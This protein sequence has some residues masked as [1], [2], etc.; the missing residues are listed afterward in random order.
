MPYLAELDAHES[1]AGLHLVLVCG[2][3]PEVT[4]GDGVKSQ[5][6]ER[7]ETSFSFEISAEFVDVF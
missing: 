7:S 1:R 6:T 5:E 4:G 3:A 2:E